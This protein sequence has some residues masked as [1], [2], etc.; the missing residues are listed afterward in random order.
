MGKNISNNKAYL[1]STIANGTKK[2]N[3]KGKETQLNGEDD[4]NFNFLSL[5][6]MLPPKVY[7]QVC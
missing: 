6:G 7:V 3:K 1:T 5:A 2:H 4:F